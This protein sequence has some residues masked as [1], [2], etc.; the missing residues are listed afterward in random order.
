MRRE[1]VLA[2]SRMRR[3]RQQ[4]QKDD[5]GV[6]DSTSKHLLG[7]FLKDMLKMEQLGGESGVGAFLGGGESGMEGDGEESPRESA[8][9]PRESGEESPRESGMS[10]RDGG[11]VPPA[12]T[13]RP[14]IP[15]LPLPGERRS[16][17]ARGDPQ[18]GRSSILK[19]PSTTSGGHQSQAQ[20]SPQMQKRC[21]LS[22]LQK[23]TSGVSSCVLFPGDGADHAQSE[24]SSA[25]PSMVQ[26]EALFSSRAG[27]GERHSV[28]AG[29]RQSVAVGERQSFEEAP[30]STSRRTV[31]DAPE[32]VEAELASLLSLFLSGELEEDWNSPSRT[33]CRGDSDWNSPIR[34][35]CSW[36]ELQRRL[37]LADPDVI[38]MLEERLDAEL[39]NANVRGSV[40]VEGAGG[41]DEAA[42]RAG[43]ETPLELSVLSSDLL[44]PLD[45]SDEPP[46]I[47]Q[48]PNGLRF[49]R[50]SGSGAS[51][52]PPR[53][54]GTPRA[55]GIKEEEGHSW[56]ERSHSGLGGPAGDGE[57]HAGSEGGGRTTVVLLGLCTSMLIC[58]STYTCICHLQY[59]G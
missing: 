58:S 37:E 16:V 42:A 45:N 55:G 40:L 1:R 46:P 59:F 24:D 25:L 3:R 48:L 10:P 17:P 2:R 22:P 13:A 56:G 26:G 20:S 15:M 41:A 4:S 51:V 9:S 47:L 31:E 44:N 28:V 27:V 8:M 39:R 34:T 50:T 30:V 54:T 57:E 7:V 18:R 49:S 6:M 23:R 52:S 5:V 11:N 12:A 19:H 53:R 43:D 29:E 32:R 36:S 21:S 35:S 33:S 38:D 14:D